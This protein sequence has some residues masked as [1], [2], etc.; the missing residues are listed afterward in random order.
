[1][2]FDHLN[3]GAFALGALQLQQSI[4]KDELIKC[5]NLPAGLYFGIIRD[6]SGHSYLGKIVIKD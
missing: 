1:V 2:I 3:F 6:K 4:Q 5:V